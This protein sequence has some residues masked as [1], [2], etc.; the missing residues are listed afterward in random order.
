MTSRVRYRTT[1]P[2]VSLAPLSKLSEAT[3]CSHGAG[4]KGRPP[5]PSPKPICNPGLL[6]NEKSPTKMF[7]SC[8][9]W[10]SACLISSVAADWTNVPRS[11]PKGSDLHGFSHQ[12]RTLGDIIFDVYAKNAS[13]PTLL[14]RLLADSVGTQHKVRDFQPTS[15]QAMQSRLDPTHSNRRKGSPHRPSQSWRGRPDPAKRTDLGLSEEKL[16]LFHQMFDEYLHFK[17]HRMGEGMHDS[18]KEL[19][20]ICENILHWQ[21][22]KTELDRGNNEGAPDSF[23]ILYRNEHY[24]DRNSTRP[25]QDISKQEKEFSSFETLIKTMLYPFSEFSNDSSS[26]EK[27]TSKGGLFPNELSILHEGLDSYPHG[28][29]PIGAVSETLLPVTEFTGDSPTKSGPN[30]TLLQAVT[31]ELSA[32]TSQTSLTTMSEENELTLTTA[33]IESHEKLTSSTAEP[34][35][36]N[37]TTSTTGSQEESAAT[38]VVLEGYPML[39]KAEFSNSTTSPVPRKHGF[40][41]PWKVLQGQGSTLSKGPQQYSS[42]TPSMGPQYHG[43]SNPSMGPQ[44]DDSLTSSQGPQRH[45]VPNQASKKHCS[46]LTTIQQ[47]KN[48]SSQHSAGN[49]TSYNLEGTSTAMETNRNVQAPPS[50]GSRRLSYPQALFRHLLTPIDNPEVIESLTI[51]EIDTTPPP[52]LNTSGKKQQEVWESTLGNVKEETPEIVI[53]LENLIKT[54]TGQL[55]KCTPTQDDMKNLKAAIQQLNSLLSRSTEA[56]ELRMTQGPS[57]V[58]WKVEVGSQHSEHTTQSAH[59]ADRGSPYIPKVVSS[60]RQ[61]GEDEEQRLNTCLSSTYPPEQEAQ[62]A[63]QR[64]SG[65]KVLPPSSTEVEPNVY[66]LQQPLG[67]TEG[68]TSR[69]N[70]S[71]GDSGFL[72][73]KR[74]KRSPGSPHG[75]PLNVP[76]TRA[77]ASPLNSRWQK[78]ST[79]PLALPPDPHRVLNRNQAPGWDAF[80]RSTSS[81]LPSSEPHILNGSSLFSQGLPPAKM[82]IL[83]PRMPSHAPSGNKPWLSK[84]A[85]A[86]SN[87]PRAV[88][89]HVV[90]HASRFAHGHDQEL[91]IV[92]KSLWSQSNGN[93]SPP[94]NSPR[95]PRLS[96]GTIQDRRDWTV[97]NASSLPQRS[98]SQGSAM[99]PSLK[100]PQSARSHSQKQSDVAHPDETLYG[101]PFGNS[102]L[103][104]KNQQETN[105]PRAS[106]LKRQ[107]YRLQNVPNKPQNERLS[108]SSPKLNAP[109][110]QNV[111][112]SNPR[113]SLRQSSQNSRFSITSQDLQQPSSQNVRSSIPPQLLLL[114]S[115]NVRS[116]DSSH[117]FNPSSPRR[118]MFSN[119][120]H[121]LKLSSPGDRRPLSSSHSFN[122]SSPKDMRSSKL[123]HHLSLL[124]PG[125]VRSSNFSFIPS[126][127][128]DRPSNPFHSQKL[129][130]PEERSSNPPHGFHQPY[131][132]NSQNSNH[133]HSLRLS[134]PVIRSSHPSHR[135]KP[136]FPGSG[137][138]SELSH[139]RNPFYPGNVRSSNSSQRL[140][141][142]SAGN[143][144]SSDL[145]H[146]LDPSSP[147]A[148]R[149]SKL[150]HSR[151]PSYSGNTRSSNSF[152]SLDLS[153][154]ENR[155]LSDPSYNLRPPISG[156]Y[157]HSTNP[158]GVGKG[159][160]SNLFYNSGPS[161]SARRL[162]HNPNSS[163]PVHEPSLEILNDPS[164]TLFKRRQQVPPLLH[165]QSPKSSQIILAPH[166]IS[167]PAMNGRFWNL[168]V[169]PPGTG[170][171]PGAYSAFPNDLP[172]DSP[173]RKTPRIH[174]IHS[175]RIPAARSSLFHPRTLSAPADGTP[176]NVTVNPD[177]MILQERALPGPSDRPIPIRRSRKPRP[178]P[179]PTLVAIPLNTPPMRR[180]VP[181]FHTKVWRRPT[182]ID[183]YHSK[184][185]DPVA[186]S[187]V[188]QLKGQMAPRDTI[189]SI[190]LTGAPPLVFKENPPTLLF[191]E[192]P[193]AAPA[194]PTLASRH[195]RRLHKIHSLHTPTSH[196]LPLRTSAEA[197]EPKLRSTAHQPTPS[198]PVSK[199]LPRSNPPTKKPGK[200]YIS[201]MTMKPDHDKAAGSA[202]K[203]PSKPPRAK[204]TPGP[205][206]RKSSLVSLNLLPLVTAHKKTPDASPNKTPLK[207]SSKKTMASNSSVWPNKRPS[208]PS[209]D[210]ALPLDRRD[211]SI[212]APISGFPRASRSHYAHLPIG[213]ATGHPD[214]FATRRAS[215]HP[216]EHHATGNSRRPTPEHP[217][218][219]DTVLTRLTS[220]MGSEFLHGTTRTAGSIANRSP[221]LPDR[222]ISKSADGGDSFARFSPRPPGKSSTPKQLRSI[223]K[224]ESLRPQALK[225]PSDNG[226]RSPTK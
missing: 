108:N 132:E 84:R 100:R 172:Q 116:S 155:R 48:M 46:H 180:Q 122:P 112:S 103:P 179:A 35:K 196:L 54:L 211:P 164:Q 33:V 72:R 89:P 83:T 27:E 102:R 223:R 144:R 96:T 139:S 137:R 199:K 135:L 149:S 101:K 111:R 213:P 152:H 34:Q 148:G 197:Q 4:L 117:R 23:P 169:H 18:K 157:L 218:V 10:L 190:L 120:S 118:K 71:A 1:S 98:L 217:P 186:H 36:D 16:K 154:P 51:E 39:T 181:H 28:W 176:S 64:V 57:G 67:G 38:T 171:V 184:G 52:R 8:L 110:P 127:P 113:H 15:G 170:P 59:G 30:T 194:I 97:F 99:R 50:N 62:E 68:Q 26:W 12:S 161:V 13:M 215:R 61:A 6:K 115:G 19:E 129:T 58:R 168:S 69:G 166:P 107:S 44:Q 203:K 195:V 17:A 79:S 126:S 159:R 124:S 119:S 145:T 70:P 14:E 156:K 222:R 31:A 138:S 183:A 204:T 32:T 146:W 85:P 131:H 90:R 201:E 123:S 74:T 93:H 128:G 47:S 220:R 178:V 134:L 130:S 78:G 221:S 21:E 192:I 56:G 86:T 200:M 7:M 41:M 224:R 225:S 208:N 174:H 216:S 37:F 95:A 205:V 82:S 193:T 73:N 76:R 163:D 91:P 45:V 189:P 49:E 125:D 143:W 141:L 121:S 80:G 188:I 165:S 209:P 2:S 142:S 167:N 175:L 173:T 106:S 212:N 53:Q 81:R 22:R 162:S 60:C 136:S 214:S 20:A 198:I 94:Q 3:D 160:F 206:E 140:T 210:A 5:A 153:L 182:T 104:P 185:L 147:G 24:Q 40:P 133:S 202:R 114:P 158:T 191:Q 187:Q 25:P 92:K 43:S 219:P 88:V 29:T 109:S 151:N 105:E 65:R 63:R 87:L 66:L 42:P 77:W 226:E 177:A 150:S 55:S 207:K 11:S 75:S 9:V